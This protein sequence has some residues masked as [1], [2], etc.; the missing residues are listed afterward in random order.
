MPTYII[1]AKDK[2]PLGPNEI[3]AGGKIQVNDGDVFIVDP[4]ADKNVEFE[5]ASG[6]STD[7]EVRFE[8]SNANKLDIKFKDDLNP[9]INIS[10]DVV[11]SDTSIDA[12]KSES[13]TV[14]VG[15]RV[16]LDQY[17]GSKDGVDTFTAGD[18]FT[19]INHLKT[20]GG[21]DVIT[22]GKNA[23]IP[24]ID[25]G[26]GYDTLI[27]Q[28]DLNDLNIKDIENTQA[29]CFTSGTL[30]TTARGPVVIEDL[31]VGDLVTT[32]DH[33][34]E[35]ICW[36]GSHTLNQDALTANPKLKPVRI[37]A[38]ALG[39]GLPSRDLTVS[40]Q[41]RVLVRSVIAERIFKTSEVL[42][43]AHKL[44]GIDGISIIEDVTEI[45]YFHLLLAKH[46]ILFSNG[47]ATES[48][49]LG[50]QA[51][52]ALDAEA[53]EEISYLFPELTDPKNAPE[54]TR[55][56]PAKGHQIKALTYRH[57]KNRKALFESLP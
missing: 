51:F 49:Y 28:T 16:T 17:R 19:M 47:A 9:T 22:I 57:S 26:K 8:V 45:T 33:G 40:R 4:T 36:I 32:L 6:S 31:R 20:E 27:S 12:D 43:P 48:L 2:D 38:G 35:P 21:D 14:N 25:G 5:S 53:M 55:L 11:L 1:V 56:I 7:F 24:K 54:S 50:P 41:H 3:N 23:S 39:S 46:E 13:V 42:I 37:S 34:E 44:V 10:D 29:I 18:N 15:D 52:A 30:I